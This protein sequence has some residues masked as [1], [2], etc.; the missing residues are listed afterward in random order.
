MKRVDISNTPTFFDNNRKSTD[1]QTCLLLSGGR[2]NN[3]IPD[4]L[5]LGG[6]SDNNNKIMMKIIM[7]MRVMTISI[8]MIKM[9]MIMTMILIM[10][11]IMIIIIIIIII[12]ILE[13]VQHQV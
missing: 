12:M 9:I 8:I 6:V 7:M 3:F 10:I 1:P 2:E 5:H 4:Y 13:G 11:M